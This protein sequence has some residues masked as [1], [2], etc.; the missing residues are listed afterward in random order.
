M[1]WVSGD[2]V[3][4]VE[5]LKSLLYCAFL[6]PPNVTITDCFDSSEEVVFILGPGPIILLETT[7]HFDEKHESKAGNALTKPPECLS[8]STFH[9]AL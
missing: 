7:L 9:R 2:P 8:S 4:R 6:K 1:Y 3:V 5:A